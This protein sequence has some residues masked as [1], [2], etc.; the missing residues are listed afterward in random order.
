MGLEILRTGSRPQKKSNCRA[1][2]RFKDVDSEGYRKPRYTIKAS[3][4]PALT[5]CQ[6]H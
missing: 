4:S 6:A 5:E 1:H 3:V 2:L